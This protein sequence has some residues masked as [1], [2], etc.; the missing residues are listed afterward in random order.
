MNASTVAQR[1][2]LRPSTVSAT[3][4]DSERVLGPD[5]PHTLTPRNNL[6]KRRRGEIDDLGVDQ[7]ISADRPEWVPVFPGLP[8]RVFGKLVRVLARRG[9]EQTGT[10][11]RWG[12]P[13][14]DRGLPVAVYYRRN[15]TFR[16]VALLSGISKPAA[17]RVVDHPAPLPALAPVTRRHSPDT[18]LIVEGT[19]APTHDRSMSASSKNY[20]YSVTMQVVIDAGTRLVVAV[21]DPHR[22][23]ATTAGPTPIPALTSSAGARK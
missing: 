10:G 15:L 14:A 5:H 11:R 3:L 4:A 7:V 17:N 13:P 20:R 22:A 23:T 2:A 6:A 18:V 16:Q 9:G 21:G 19:V 8:V 1:G 12:L